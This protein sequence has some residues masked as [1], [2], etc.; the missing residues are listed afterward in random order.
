MADKDDDKAFDLFEVLAACLLGLGAVGAAL[1]GYQGGLWGGTMTDN[2]SQSAA[3]N[4]KGSALYSEELSE[5][6]ADAQSNLRAKELTWAALETDNEDVRNRNFAV[7]SWIYVSQMTEHGYAALKLPPEARKAYSEK[8]EDQVFSSAQLEAA[9]NRDLDED[10]SYETALYAGSKAE[11]QKAEGLL[12]DARNANTIGDQFSLAGVI[13]TIGLF[14]AGLALV[15]KSGIRWG[16]LG[17]GTLVFAG[18]L[19]YML[20]LPWV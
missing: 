6:I 5:E 17:A 11:F 2:Y 14:F 1:A 8:G 15:F 9:L 19:V 7:A 20:R 16:F 13:Q 10:E 18:G 12:A 4:T 3:S